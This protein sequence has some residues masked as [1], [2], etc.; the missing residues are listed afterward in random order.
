MN[1]LK[2]IRKDFRAHWA[3]QLDSMLLLFALST[4]FIYIMLQ[5]NG[6]ADPELVIYFLV[7]LL[8]TSIVS[9]L[10]M[11]MDEL[12]K[13]DEIFVSLPVTRT[14]I[15]IAKYISSV[16]QV[17]LA[18]P[19]HFLGVQLGAYFNGSLGN[20]E[21]EIIYNP[22]LW[23][24]MGAILLF[25]KTYAYPL[26]FKFGLTIG[27]GIHTVIQFLLLV[28][29]ILSFQLFNL[30]LLIEQ[31]INWVSVKNGYLVFAVLLVAFIS[32][33]SLSV[34]LSSKIYKNKAI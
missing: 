8:S 28:I 34:T 13:M 21:L 17:L 24:A 2:L 15:V 27:A 16:I 26:Y 7:M 10:F 6:K 4:L 12:Y 30:Q 11:K 25:F 31:I 9:L 14:E 29:L 19:V 1:I 22:L 23:F 20:P 33:M 18:L 5:G 32:V 3:Y